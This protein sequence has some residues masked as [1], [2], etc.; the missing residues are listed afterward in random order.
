MELFSKHFFNNCPLPLNNRSNLFI[1]FPTEVCLCACLHDKE[2][3]VLV[4]CV[5]CE[6][7]LICSLPFWFDHG[8]WCLY[9]LSMDYLT[10]SFIFIFI[11]FTSSAFYLSV[12]FSQVPVIPSSVVLLYWIDY[13]Q[14]ERSLTK[15]ASLPELLSSLGFVFFLK[16]N[17]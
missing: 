12:G 17:K 1:F 5:P 10:C 15:L 4:L 3:L 8:T 6:L 9:T 7:H 2:C 11:F 14:Y 13:I 16:I